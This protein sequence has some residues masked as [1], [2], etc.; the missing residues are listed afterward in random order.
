[1]AYVPI[2][3]EGKAFINAVC[4][5]SKTGGAKLL[6]GKNKYPMPYTGPP[7]VDQTWTANFTYN[8]TLVTTGEMLAEALIAWF[9][10]YGEDYEMDAN[11]IAAQAYVE[12]RYVMWTYSGGDSAA[13]GVNQFEM[14]TFFGIVVE[15]AGST[16]KMTPIEIATLTAGLDEN[17]SRDSYN[18]RS[19]T[20]INARHNRPILHQNIINNPELI[21]KA[22]CRYM[23]DIANKS[24]SL[25]STTLFCY[26]RGLYMSNTYT[27][28]IQ[29]CNNAHKSDPDYQKSG[30]DYA[31]KVFGVL[32]DQ[33][34]FLETKGLPQGYKLKG[35]CFGYNE[36]KG[37]DDPKNLKL[38]EGF[39]AFGANVAES[40]DFNLDPKFADDKV[41]EYLSNNVKDYRYIYYPSNRYYSTS[42]EKKQIVLHHT[43]S[44]D[45]SAQDILWWEKNSDRVAV[46]FIITRHG[47]I[48]QLFSTNYWAY[49]LGITDKLLSEYGTVGINNEKLNSESIGI[50]IDS[51]GGLVYS[52]GYWYPP[53]QNSNSVADTRNKPIPVADV[54]Q[55]TASQYSKGYHG[56]Y[57]FE[58]YTPEQIKALRTLIYAIGSVW[59]KIPLGYVNDIYSSDS[60]NMWGKDVVLGVWT[61]EH[62]AYAQKLG[63]WTHVSY[64]P[65]K[66]D[67]HP[68]PEL[69]TMLKS[70]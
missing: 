11:V 43:A 42:T 54:I 25:T 13:S 3:E 27:K 38:T 20:F 23:K 59:T 55:Y 19:S 1:M 29:R 57:G 14:L 39:N 2:T 6:S 67:C 52:G 7:L 21:I 30:L 32:G 24:D 16:E 33:N 18:I 48:L 17:R 45:G 44:G 9:N 51:W 35:K 10:K 56:F 22:Q 68:Q 34:N 64:L 53:I 70:L 28:S 65:D 50:E 36:S 49:H 60:V 37:K 61:A 63:I 12:S 62:D 5:D 69:I 8:G 58:R 66:S 31:L 4:T 46:S 26:N 40:A 41:A 47:E 15:N